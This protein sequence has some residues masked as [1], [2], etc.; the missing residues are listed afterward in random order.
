MDL[1]RKMELAWVIQMGITKHLMSIWPGFTPTPFILYDADNQVAVGSDWPE[2]YRLEKDNMWIAEGIDPILMGNTAIM[3]H[4]KYVAIWDTR[5]WDESTLNESRATACIAHE[6]FH[7]YQYS[8]MELP[9]ANELLMPNYPHS[10]K[11]VALVIQEGKLLARLID[12]SRRITDNPTTP[13]EIR[14]RLAT[15]SVLRKLRKEEIG[16]E[17]MEYDERIE[18]IEGTAA[19]VEVTAKTRLEGISPIEAA[20][21]YLT[22]LTKNDTLLTD[23]RHRC[24]ASGLILSLA[25]DIAFTDWKTEW[26]R[27]G[28]T[29]F[30][31]MEKKLSLDVMSEATLIVNAYENEKT[32][33]ISEFREQSLSVVATDN[34]ELI[35]FDPMNLVFADGF[36][37]HQQ[38]SVRYG[39]EEHLLT[40]PFLTECRD[41]ILNIAKLWVPEKL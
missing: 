27:S 31:W 13:E 25:A 38:G 19:Y 21:S 9:S 17:H 33:L 6:M 4:G 41:N 8:C 28:L 3:Y 18:S 37:L 32:R 35:S 11:S 24:Y 36:C 26:E 34:I 12:K 1:N 10:P 7:A 2:R 30:Q 23:Y 16:A 22:L 5:T 15:I 29:L 14:N 39:G 40:Q 20:E